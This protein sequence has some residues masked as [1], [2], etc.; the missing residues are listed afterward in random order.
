LEKA[1]HVWSVFLASASIAG[2]FL[3]PSVQTLTCVPYSLYV[4]LNPT[5]THNRSHVGC[6]P[7][8]SR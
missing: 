5:D 6:T 8:A 4:P 2:N 1:L 7:S 3:A